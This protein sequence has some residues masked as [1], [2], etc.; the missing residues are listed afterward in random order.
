MSVFIQFARFYMAMRECLVPNKAQEAQEEIVADLH[1]CLEQLNERSI[2]LENRIDTCT[3]RIIVHAKASKNSNASGVSKIRERN[4]AKQ[5]LQ[6]KKRAQLEHEK[7]SKNIALIQ[8]QID[9]IISSQLNMVVIDTMKHFNYNAI[10]MS[11]PSRTIEVETLEEQLAERSKEISE[12]HE[13]LHG[14]SNTCSSFNNTSM[15]AND[16]DEDK[17]LWD[18][19]DS[20]LTVQDDDANSQPIDNLEIEKSKHTTV[21]QEVKPEAD[22]RPEDIEPESVKPEN[23][24]VMEA[25]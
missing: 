8:Q 1:T 13:A 22:V 4:L 9:N 6:D 5:Y 20:Y 24:G 25:I 18:E 2:D 23:L 14:V 10:R 12:F 3:Q 7:L 19:I 21:K 17:Q 16:N 11:L 15:L